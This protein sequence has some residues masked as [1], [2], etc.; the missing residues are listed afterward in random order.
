MLTT[1]KNIHT[2]NV[3]NLLP[4]LTACV[5]QTLAVRPAG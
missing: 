1:T 3:F 2:I 5:L 4:E